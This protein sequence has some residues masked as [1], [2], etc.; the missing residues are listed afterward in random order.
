MDNKSSSKPNPTEYKRRSKA[1]EIWRNYR[2]SFSGML[3]LF[4]IL[5]VIG[6]GVWGNIHYDYD[7]EIV[8]MNILEAKQKPSKA[9]LFGT[10]EMGRDILKRVIYATRYSISIAFISA[11]ISSVVGVALGSIAGFYGGPVDAVIMRLT[12]VIGSIPAILFG[13]TVVAAF[14]QNIFILMLALA[15]GG[16]SAIVRVA[17]ASVMQVRGQEYIEA[18]R[19]TGVKDFKIIIDHVLPNALSPII[20]QSTLR[21]GSAII[22]IASL[23]FLGLGISPPTP[24]WGAMLSSGRAFI[25]GFGYMTIFPGLAIMITVLSLNLIGDGLRDAMDPKLKK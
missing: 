19:A 12:D 2:K 22:G 23:S 10:D 7:T 24:E 3:G 16:T 9:H 11:I 25:R 14:G 5:L 1:Q 8:N 21:T 18:A 4:L 17:R 13:I 20:V 6:I 15:I